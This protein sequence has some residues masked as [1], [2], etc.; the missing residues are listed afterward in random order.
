MIARPL[1]AGVVAGWI[2]GDVP[3]G[4]TIGVILELFALDLLPVGAARYPDYGTGAVAA[5][6]A[7]GGAPDVF[8]LGLA[9]LLGLVIAYGAQASIQLMREWT[10]RDVRRMAQAL[11]AGDPAAIRRMHF[12]GLGRDALRAFT[13]SALSVFGAVA[14]RALPTA[15]VRS[16]AL[17]QLAAFGAAVGIGFLGAARLAGREVGRVW[18]VA[19]LLTGMAWVALR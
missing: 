6:L 3:T 19:G 14:V 15:G 8:G 5:T 18:L 10:A 2:V 13:L 11:D 12:R 9:V 7:A 1:V 16:T 17:L 4:A